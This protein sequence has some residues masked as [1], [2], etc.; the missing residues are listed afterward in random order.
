MEQT[1]DYFYKKNSLDGSV[2]LDVAGKPVFDTRP[3]DTLTLADLQKDITDGRPEK[4]LLATARKV[5]IGLNWDIYDSYIKQYSDYLTEC[6]RINDIN[7]ALVADEDGNTPDDTPLPTE[8]TIAPFEPSTVDSVMAIVA[9]T[10]NDIQREKDKRAAFTYKDVVCSVCESDQNGWFALSDWIRDDLADGHE[11]Q[12]F[13]FNM[14]NGNSVLIMS[15]EEWN[16]FK[17]LSKANR[18]A[19]FVD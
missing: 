15:L 2:I 14:E 3:R 11:F 13:P 9:D 18:K 12:P 10:L 16:E 7:N 8:P 1:I 19:F 4:G 17:A 6:N 5:A